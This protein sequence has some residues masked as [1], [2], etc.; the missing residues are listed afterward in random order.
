LQELASEGVVRGLAENFFSFI[1]YNMDPE[2]FERTVAHEI[3]GAVAQEER[4]DV[5]LLAPA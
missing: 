5:A 3:A 2:K 1:G 4:A